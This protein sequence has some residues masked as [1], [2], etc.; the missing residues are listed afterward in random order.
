MRKNYSSRVDL[1]AALGRDR[2]AWCV[3]SEEGHKAMSRRGPSSYW[4]SVSCIS[5]VALVVS[6]PV[7]RLWRNG[8]QLV[9]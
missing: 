9:F 2:E 6:L 1:L 8:L 5:Y 3:L 7:Q 4:Q